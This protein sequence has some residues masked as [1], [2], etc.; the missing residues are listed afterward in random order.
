MSVTQHIL[1]KRLHKNRTIAIKKDLHSNL[2][3]AVFLVTAEFN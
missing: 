3:R 2:K 1:R